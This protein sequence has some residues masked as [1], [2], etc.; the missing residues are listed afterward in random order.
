MAAAITVSV[1]GVSYA[2]FNT[3][4]LTERAQTVADAASCHTVDD[5]IVAYVAVH[6]DEP[7]SIADLQPYVRGDISAWRIENGIAA[8]PGC[9]SSAR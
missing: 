7:R 2:A 6:S 1:V 8:G 9:T 5:A 4:A 3:D